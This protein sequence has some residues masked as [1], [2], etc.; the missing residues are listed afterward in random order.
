MKWWKFY[1]EGVIRKCSALHFD[2]SG[3]HLEM[4][5]HDEIFDEGAAG[6]VGVK[7]FLYWVK[8]YVCHVLG[9]YEF[10]KHWSVVLMDNA[11]THMCD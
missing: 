5:L 3:R 10:G 7:Y 11:S 6:T 1:Y 9:Y 4:F 2:C 8:K